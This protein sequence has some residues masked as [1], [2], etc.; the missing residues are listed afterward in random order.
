MAT[1]AVP[2]PQGAQIGSP[3][4]IA[5]PA[6]PN[7]P[8]GATS[9]GT[10]IPQGAQVGGQ[11]PTPQATISA[12][13]EPTTFIGKFGRWAENVSND[14]KYGTDETG[15]GTVLK[16][17]G[18]HGVYNGHPEAVGDFMASLPLGLLKMAKGTSELTPEVMGGPQGKTMQGLKDVVGGGLQAATMPAAFV[19]PEAGEAGAE[20]A[21]EATEAAGQG[22]KAAGEAVGNTVKQVVKGAKVAQEPAKEALREGGRAAQVESGIAEASPSS[23]RETLA[24]PI[25]ASEN[26]ADELYKQIDDASGADFKA[27]G[28]R[29]KNANR[30]LRKAVDDTEV[31]KATGDRDDI[32]KAIEVAK[33][34]ATEGD[35]DPSVLD[36]ADSHFKRMSALSD[37]E[38]KVFKNPSIITGNSAH[39]TPEALNVDSAIKAFQKL[40][41]SEKYG[42]PRLEQAFGKDGAKALLDNLYAAQREGVHAVK[43][44]KIA[45]WVGGGLLLTGAGRKVLEGASAIQ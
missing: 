30:A 13:K 7:A 18:A 8:Q 14:L 1:T 28:T 6:G 37:V 38:S 5:S 20:L 17:M 25:E 44:Q 43:M 32:E 23:L 4:P 15:I 27:L 29:L 21:G 24:K 42:A 19:A 2:I 33:Q 16:K 11:A 3:G 34:K 10:P 9:G 35:V 39:G 41:D 45:K 22:V 36:E 40:Q 26:K 31:A 12:V